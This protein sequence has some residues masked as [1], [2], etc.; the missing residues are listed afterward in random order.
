MP[1]TSEFLI[2]RRNLCQP[3]NSA[4]LTMTRHLGTVCCL[5]VWCMENL[6]GSKFRWLAIIQE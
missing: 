6:V 5:S 2:T 3:V 4:L 1:A